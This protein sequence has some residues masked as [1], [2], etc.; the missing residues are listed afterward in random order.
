MWRAVLKASCLSIA[1]LATGALSYACTSNPAPPAKEPERCKL[2]ILNMTILA[3]SRLNPTEYGEARPVQLRLYQMKTDARFNFAEFQDVWKNDQKALGDDMVAMQEL[4]IYPESRTEV[5]FE[6]DES[7]LNV[8]AAALFRNPS[9]RTWWSSFELPPPPGKGD[10]S[11][12]C[13]DGSCDGGTPLNPHYVVWLDGTRVDDGEDHLD[14]YPEG[15]W[16]RMVNAKLSPVKA[17]E[18]S[19]Q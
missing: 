17:S 4:S 2:Q 9:G 19:P 12:N 11:M 1:V 13:K 14:D 18:R 6:R 15:K 3:S 16:P 7:A 10:C 5:R 8:V